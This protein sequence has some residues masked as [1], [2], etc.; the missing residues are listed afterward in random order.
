MRYKCDEQSHDIKSVNLNTYTF[1][2]EYFWHKRKTNK[3]Y[4]IYIYSY[5]TYADHKQAYNLYITFNNVCV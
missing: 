2:M 4:Y 5:N 1:I 3:R